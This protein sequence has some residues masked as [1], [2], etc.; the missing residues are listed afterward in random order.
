MLY[1]TINT[2]KTKLKIKNFLI[3]VEKKIQQKI[4]NLTFIKFISVPD[5]SYYMPFDMSRAKIHNKC[6]L[7]LYEDKKTIFRFNMF[8]NFSSAFFF[9]STQ[10]KRDEK[11]VLIFF[12]QNC[13]WMEEKI[14]R[15]V[16]DFY[17]FQFHISLIINLRKLLQM[18]FFLSPAK[19]DTK[20]KERDIV[21]WYYFNKSRIR[22]SGTNKTKI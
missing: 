16:I 12:R 14:M 3:V 19:T 17:M 4:W 1:Q 10:R 9:C 15:W 7:W 8:T 6:D 21:T 20:V 22:S 11:E 5:H 2:A 13:L 18:T